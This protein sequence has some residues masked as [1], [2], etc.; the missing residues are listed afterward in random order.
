MIKSRWP[1]PIA[2]DEEVATPGRAVDQ[3]AG[4]VDQAEEDGPAHA[5]GSDEEGSR[6]SSGRSSNSSSQKLVS[7]YIRWV[8]VTPIFDKYEQ[9]NL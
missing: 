8:N 2:V 3:G 5:E 4:G 1:Y 7:M 9:N 6:A